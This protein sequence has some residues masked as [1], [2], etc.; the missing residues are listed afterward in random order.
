MEITLLRHG[1]LVHIS[2]DLI[3]IFG[4]FGGELTYSRQRDP[5][6]ADTPF[7]EKPAA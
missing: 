5:E 2:G 6:A 3:H 7:H 4:F 1:R